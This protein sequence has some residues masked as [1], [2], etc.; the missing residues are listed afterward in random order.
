TH[1]LVLSR[2]NF[3]TG[4]PYLFH[5]SSQPAISD[6]LIPYILMSCKRRRASTLS[7]QGTQ[8][9]EEHKA[10]VE[11][12]TITSQHGSEQQHH[13]D[14]TSSTPN[15]QLTYPNLFELQA[16]QSL[17]II[18]QFPEPFDSVPR[19]QHPS[20]L[21]P[22]LRSNRSS[23][24]SNSQASMSP[25][26]AEKI[27]TGFR[28]FMD[29][30]VH[31]PKD[32]AQFVS[33]LKKPRSSTTVTPN[34][35]QVASANSATRY[36]L[37]NNARH[38]LLD[39]LI[40]PVKLNYQDPNDEGQTA[41]W[42]GMDDPWGDHVPQPHGGPT[43]EEKELHNVMQIIGAPSKPKPDASFGYAD[44]FLDMAQITRLRGWHPETLV[45]ESAP[46]FPYL[47]VEWKGRDKTIQD[48]RCQARRDCP[49]AI[50]A[51]HKLFV[52]SGVKEPSAKSTCMFS[53]CVDSNVAE[54]R[55]H[56][57]EVDIAGR[58]SYQA[59]LIAGALLMDESSVFKLR[60]TLLNALEWARGDRLTAIQKALTNIKE[61]PQ[62]SQQPKEAKEEET[63]KDGQADE[64]PQKK[65][66]P[67]R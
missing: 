37:E 42:R 23:S 13:P 66:E 12:A 11:T 52:A 31:L 46:W 54:H 50:E 63:A 51:L 32:L 5:S 24:K 30:G 17:P 3:F 67:S 43:K 53:L 10:V 21:D 49:T 6:I 45:Y 57:R 20:P 62:Q 59:E 41:I 22:Y 34:S 14:Q 65:S 60:G 2:V 16:D 4:D 58:V 39:R 25:T 40:Y 33:E 47:A 35:K 18:P 61:P 9:T 36:M 1:H 64:S 7:E 15:N 44:N 56:W 26:E 38:V 48:A 28:F 29:R 19:E 27:L 55:I 8:S